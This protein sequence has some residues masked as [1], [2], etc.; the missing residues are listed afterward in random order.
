MVQEPASRS[1][2]V[3]SGGGRR[4]YASANGRRVASARIAVRIF[5]RRGYRGI[6]IATSMDDS[7]GAWNLTFADAVEDG[8]QRNNVRDLCCKWISAL[9][10]IE[11]SRQGMQ[12]VK[13][14][15]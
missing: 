13:P 4:V 5:T 14:P 11:V 3:R 8:G 7:A 1:H 9:L 6:A 15:T 2:C 12:F 10:G